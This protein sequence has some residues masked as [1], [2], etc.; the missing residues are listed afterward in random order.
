[1]VLTSAH[2]EGFLWR[3]RGHSSV[4]RASDWQSEGRRFDPDWLHQKE[5]GVASFR[6][7]FFYVR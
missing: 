1:M 5:Q 4:G 3:E 2:P 6:S 7:P